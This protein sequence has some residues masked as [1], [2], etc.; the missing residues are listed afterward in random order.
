[1][2][3]KVLLNRIF[4]VGLAFSGLFRFAKLDRTMYHFAYGSTHAARIAD[5]VLQMTC[6]VF[7]ARPNKI[8]RR[9]Q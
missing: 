4:C 3:Q 8:K 6:K 2:L 5:L 1:M 9:L 7:V